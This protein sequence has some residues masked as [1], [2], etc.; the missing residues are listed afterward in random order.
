[1]TKAKGFDEFQRCILT[2]MGEELRPLLKQ[3]WKPLG[4][5]IQNHL[6]GLPGPTELNTP[7]TARQLHVGKIFSGFIEIVKSVETLQLI[8]TCI[9]RS[10]SRSLSVSQ[11]RYLQFFYEAHL[12]E[13]YVLQ[14][15][16]CRYLK[17]IERQFR[18]SIQL[19]EIKKRS[20]PVSK[21]VIQALENVVKVRGSHV[22]VARAYDKNIARLGTMTLLTKGSDKSFKLAIEVLL[23]DEARKIR[24]QWK[25][26]VADN[27]TAIEKLL[28][29]YFEALHPLIFEDDGAIKYPSR[30]G[31]PH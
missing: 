3:D 31:G 14:Q 2:A 26:K 17:T 6:L 16:L 15:R 28:D 25:S 13:L 19:P 18:R 11:D 9:G 21:F 8:V 12:H 22:H 23:R 10:P 24:K 7:R 30:M 1:M 29:A 27:N 20:E 4:K 5:V